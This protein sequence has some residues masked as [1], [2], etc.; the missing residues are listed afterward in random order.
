[1]DTKEGVNRN[2]RKR[3]YGAR[4]KE[5]KIKAIIKLHE[6]GYSQVEIAKMLNISRGTILRWNKSLN[7]IIPKTPGEAGKLKC[8]KYKY[9]EDYFSNIINANQAYLVGYILGDGTISDRKKSKRLIL[10]LAEQDKQLLFDIAQEL[11]MTDAVKFRKKNAQNEQNKYSLIINSTKMCNDLI[12]LGVTPKKTFNES[13]IE[14]NNVELQWS[15]LRGFFDADGHIRVYYRDGRLKTRA[16]FTGTKGILQSILYFL[17]SHGIGNNVKRII[18][19]QGCYDLYFSSIDEVRLMF[20]LLYKYGD[21]K[22]NRKYEKFSS[23][24]I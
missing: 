13:W 16:G 20:D 3:P 21:L 17:N 8:K 23:L 9:N 15:F 5:E 24:M 11:N 19:K 10:T 12:N 4:D 22:L 6:Q 2:V 14:F 18:P 1:M 7:F